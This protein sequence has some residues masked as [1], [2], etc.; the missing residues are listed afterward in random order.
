MATGGLVIEAS[1]M[2]QYGDGSELHGELGVS[3]TREVESGAQ[4]LAIDGSCQVFEIT[5]P[6]GAVDASCDDVDSD[7]PDAHWDGRHLIELQ[8]TTCTGSVER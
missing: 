6:V 5:V 1:D 8:W 4:D 7:F 2:Q 3:L